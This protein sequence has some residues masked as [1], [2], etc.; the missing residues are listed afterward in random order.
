MR[1]FTIVALLALTGALYPVAT[2]GADHKRSEHGLAAH[3]SADRGKATSATRAADKPAKSPHAT[4]CVFNTTL[5]SHNEVPPSGSLATGHTQIKVRVN[6]TIQFKTHLNNPGGETFTAGHIHQAPAG[7]NGPVVQPIFVGGP[8]NA[9][10]ITQHGSVSNP[11]LG[12]AICADP[13]A[14]YVNYHSVEHPGGALRGQL[15]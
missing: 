5:D 14:Y 2:A 13:S 12:S 6:G 8:T 15:G 1:R 9:H 10:E 4:A 7:V 3:R 11:S